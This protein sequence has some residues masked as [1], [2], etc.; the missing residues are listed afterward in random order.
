MTVVVSLTID[1]HSLHARTGAITPCG[2][3]GL[4]L[5]LLF[6]S[7]ALTTGADLRRQLSPD[8]I[9]YLLLI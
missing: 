9:T 1:C 5:S 2:G 7:L 3:D 6:R 4:S 8:S